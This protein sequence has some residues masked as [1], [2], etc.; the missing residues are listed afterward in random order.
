MCS[1]TVVCGKTKGKGRKN[2]IQ[3]LHLSRQEAE[4]GKHQ[5]RDG[6]TQQGG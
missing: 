6:R 4:E 5:G 1:D 2:Q 3:R